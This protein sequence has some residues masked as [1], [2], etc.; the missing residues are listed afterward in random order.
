MAI[1]ATIQYGNKD[2]TWLETLSL[3][4]TTQVLD[5]HE[6]MKFLVLIQFG[7]Q[8]NHMLFFL[9]YKL[10]C[11]LSGLNGNNDTSQHMG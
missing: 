10:C 4:Q 3:P 7:N 8:S 5:I 11:D 1:V 9:I 6:L 2:D